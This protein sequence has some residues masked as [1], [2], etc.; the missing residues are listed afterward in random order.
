MLSR[1]VVMFQIQ[2]RELPCTRFHFFEMIE[3]RH[4]LEGNTG[5]VI[6]FSTFRNIFHEDLNDL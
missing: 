5:P 2:R 6:S 3:I 1:V 4:E